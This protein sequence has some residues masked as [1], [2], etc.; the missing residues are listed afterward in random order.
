MKVAYA[1]A[2]AAAPRPESRAQTTP[3]IEPPP[4]ATPVVATDG[5]DWTLILT[6]IGTAAAVISALAVIVALGYWLR[7][8]KRRAARDELQVAMAEDIE[9]MQS[10]VAMI[11]AE[12]Q[13]RRPRPT[14]QFALDDGPS[15]SV[16]LTRQALR[17]VDADAIVEAEK[18]AALATLMPADPE[19]RGFDAFGAYSGCYR[20]ITEADREMFRED[21]EA[22]EKDLRRFL[23]NWISYRQFT[24][25]IAVLLGH[26]DNNGGGP[27]LDARVRFHFPDPFRKADWPERPVRPRRPKFERPENPIY[28]IGRVRVPQPIHIPKPD[29]PNLVG[30][31][32]EE[33]S[34]KVQFDFES[35]P[36]ADPFKTPAFS[37]WC[38]KPG[39]YVIT[40]TV[41]AANLS[42]PE[43][44]ELVCEIRDEEPDE[45][46]ISAL[47]DLLT[48]RRTES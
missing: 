40:W 23:K 25:P 29:L 36:H 38:D 7:T 28:S 18:R 19:P 41:H 11:A 31:F 14:V 15:M 33:G 3:T 26:V 30:P 22:Y 47:A 20:R 8:R 10:V 35:I 43:R 37:V 1:L 24:Q 27:A 42:Q 48:E 6:A 21:V 2:I 12:T 34:V 4:P 46:P 44:G 32:Y 45:T 17:P 5:P 9:Q 39:T 16:V 13:G